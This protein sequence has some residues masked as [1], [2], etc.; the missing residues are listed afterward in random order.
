MLFY[1]LQN[2]IINGSSVNRIYTYITVLVRPTVLI[3][4]KE[5][6]ACQASASCKI[7]ITQ[8]CI[9]IN[10]IVKNGKRK[11]P[12]LVLGT[13]FNPIKFSGGGGST[14]ATG[15][16]KVWAIPGWCFFEEPVSKS[17]FERRTSIQTEV[18]SFPFNYALTPG[19][20][21]PYKRLMGM[22]RWMGSHFHGWIDYNG[23]AFSISLLEWGRT[24]SDFGGKKNSSHLRL[25][26]LANVPECLYCR[27]KVE[28]SSFIIR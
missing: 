2:E 15:S 27:W 16:N 22:F 28:C 6:E 8:S 23:A 12:I 14:K 5:C 20:V 25:A 24:F 7:H 18:R 10:W 4:G 21:L 1:N 13:N 3:S 19:E 26:Q 17:V 11:L 9:L